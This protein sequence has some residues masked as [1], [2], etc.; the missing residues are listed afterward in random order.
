MALWDSWE[1]KRP[2]RAT[3]CYVT[4]LEVEV[5]GP[6]LYTQLSS[7][8]LPEFGQITVYISESQFPHL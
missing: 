4:N 6:E 1:V 5:G 3:W 7:N 2:L 8:E